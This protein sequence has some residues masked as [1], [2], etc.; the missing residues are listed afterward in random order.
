MKNARLAPCTPWYWVYMPYT[1]VAVEL[2]A[3]PGS[4]EVYEIVAKL[5][6]EASVE[7]TDGENSFR[8][9]ATTCRHSTADC[10]R[11]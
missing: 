1:I 2:L 3:A 9:V 8:L 11:Y 7:L 5:R 4:R 10:G 6:P